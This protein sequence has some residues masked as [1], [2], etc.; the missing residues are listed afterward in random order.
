M[1]SYMSLVDLIADYVVLHLTAQHRHDLA[2]FVEAY[3]E[4]IAIW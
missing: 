1:R 2:E 4:E 3:L